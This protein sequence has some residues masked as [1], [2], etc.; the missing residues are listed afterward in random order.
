[1]LCFY[2]SAMPSFKGEAAGHPLPLVD[3]VDATVL[4]ALFEGD[5]CC[6]TYMH[7]SVVAAS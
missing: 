6:S 7:M 4:R 5:T 3:T 2:G 1:M